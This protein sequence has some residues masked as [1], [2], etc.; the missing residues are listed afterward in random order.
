MR[1][2]SGSSLLS[3]ALIVADLT[4]TQLRRGF[5]AHVRSKSYQAFI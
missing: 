5:V 4:M 1:W 2:Q 3:N